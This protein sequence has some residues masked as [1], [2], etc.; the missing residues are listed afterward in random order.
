MAT[1]PAPRTTHVLAPATPDGDG[2]YYKSDVKVTLTATDN[3]GGSGVDNTEYRDAGAA[4]WTAYSAP[5]D[6]T[7]AGSH[8][9]EY[10]S[11]DKKGNV[12]STRGH[13]QDRQDRAG[14]QRQ[15]QRRGAEGIATTVTSR[16][17]STPRTRPRA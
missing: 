5:F 14:D 13:V 1:R 3:A 4:T 2:G 10:R 7:T 9:I 16:S 8:T 12:E 17:T 11:V 6:V 15:A